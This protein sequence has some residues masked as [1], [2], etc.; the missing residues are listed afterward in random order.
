MSTQ[1][2]SCQLLESQKMIIQPDVKKLDDLINEFKALEMPN[3][4]VAQAILDELGLLE[5][6]DLEFTMESHSKDERLAALKMVQRYWD[7]LVS[8]EMDRWQKA[9]KELAEI[10]YQ[11]STVDEEAFL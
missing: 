3:H 8:G 10:Y 7:D 9:K 1:G 6:A 4:K 2:K 5:I 11:V